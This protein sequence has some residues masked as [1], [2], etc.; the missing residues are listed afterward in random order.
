MT[1]GAI[2][3]W[4]YKRGGFLNITFEYRTIDAKGSNWNNQV[5]GLSLIALIP[6]R[7]KLTLQ[8]YGET[9]RWEYDNIHTSTLIPGLGPPRARTDRSYQGSAALTWEF[10][11][12]TTLVLQFIA[13]RDDSNLVQFDDDRQIYIAG[14][15]CSF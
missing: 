13:I 12:H 8:L 3:S 1:H 2:R 14:V 10:Y 5:F 11:K 4:W 7:D 9:A 6:L 15:E